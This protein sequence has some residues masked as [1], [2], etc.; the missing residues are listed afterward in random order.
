MGCNS[1]T[2]TAEQEGIGRPADSRAF[3]VEGLDCAE[4]VEALRRE[5]GPV[6]GGA[7]R[8]AVEV[9]LKAAEDP[10]VTAEHDVVRALFRMVVDS[11]SDD[12]AAKDRAVALLLAMATDDNEHVARTGGEVAAWLRHRGALGDQQLQQAMAR[13]IA[14][15]RGIAKVVEDL[16]IEQNPQQWLRELAIK[17]ATDADPQ[18]GDTV[19]YAFLKPSAATLLSEREFMERLITA[20]TGAGHDIRPLVEACDR[21]A[22]LRP[23]AEIILHAAENLTAE[24]PTRFGWGDAGNLPGLLARLLEEAERNGDFALRTR[25]LDAWDAV[26]DRDL[27]PAW[28]A[29]ANRMVLP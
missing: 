16:L 13:G 4:E 23:I 2:G 10:L 18:T 29:I 1:S 3:N 24:A 28:A 21:E 5:V 26:L 17:L 6:A 19:L 11:G 25:A 12:E 15:R 9:L 27:P 20:A 22:S 8:H 7:S 14:V